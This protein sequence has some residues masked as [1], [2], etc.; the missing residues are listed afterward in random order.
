MYQ[1]MLVTSLAS[2]AAVGTDDTEVTEYPRVTESE[3][4]KESEGDNTLAVSRAF[5]EIIDP[6]PD[7]KL[8]VLLRCIR[9]FEMLTGYLI[10]MSADENFWQPTGG[11]TSQ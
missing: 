5:S 4:P 7:A 2:T 10:M 8:Q 11:D 6:L 9:Q 1:L 3:Y